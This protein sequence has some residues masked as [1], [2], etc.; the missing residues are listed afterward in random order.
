M[1]QALQSLERRNQE[2]F[3]LFLCERMM[4][5][6]VSF[7]SDTGYDVLSY[8][9]FLDDC[10]DYL[11]TVR[12]LPRDE[13]LPDPPDMDDFTHPLKS[14]ALNAAISGQNLKQFLHK[15]DLGL[16][17]V[18]ATLAID[19]VSFFLQHKLDPRISEGTVAYN[20]EELERLFDI[21]NSDPLMQRELHR[22]NEDVA[23]LEGLPVK[24]HRAMVPHFKQRAL[25]YKL[26]NGAT[27]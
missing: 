17:V 3:L 12:D 8:R 5:D 18:A 22:Q 26:Y 21:I 9:K 19:S 14:E 15:A 6:F 2:L 1:R 13:A 27:R 20:R 7:G 10:W 16:I 11:A 25:N 4:P 24:A 23:F